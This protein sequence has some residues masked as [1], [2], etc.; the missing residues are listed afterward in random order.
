MSILSKCAAFALLLAGIAPAVGQ[1]AAVQNN[2]P[3]GDDE[4]RS[5]WELCTKNY[6][7][8]P[9]SVRPPRFKAGWENCSAIGAEFA[10]RSD[11][12]VEAVKK[13]EVEDAARRL[14]IAPAAP[15]PG[16]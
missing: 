6:D 4:L 14:K 3:V 11:A 1:P 8:R 5:L 16:R 2:T 7:M 13:K 10:K 12:Q 9:P 15:G